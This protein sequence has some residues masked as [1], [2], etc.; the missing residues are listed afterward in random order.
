MKL[1]QIQNSLESLSGLGPAK[2]KLF[3]R[4]N[5]FTVADLLSAYPKKYEDRSKKIPLCQFQLYPKVY[6][7][8]K[9]LSHEWFGYGKMKTLKIFISDGSAKAC[10]VAFNRPFLEKN[11]PVSSIIQ[12]CGKFEERYGQIQSTSFEAEVIYHDGNLEEIQKNFHLST[13]MIPIYSLCQGLSQKNYQKAVKEALRIYG[14]SIEDDLPPQIVKE[15]N[16][17][18]KSE[19]LFKI[20]NPK[21]LQDINL[22]RKTII[23]EELFFFE[24][25][26]ALRSLDHRGSLP[27]L[28]FSSQEKSP[29][30]TDQKEMDEKFR[31]S[32][33]P[34][35]QELLKRLPF[36][37]TSDQK[38]V[39]L[40]MNREI[41]KSQ[42]QANTMITNPE[43][44]KANPFSMQRLLQG[45]VGSGKTLV[46]FFICLRSIDYGGQCAILAPTE[47]LAKQ[48]AENAAR[49]LEAL[50]VKVAFLTGNV[51][52]KGR[53]NLLNA[54]KEGLVNIVIGTHALFSQNVSYKKLTLAVIDE[55]HR[56]GV[57]QRESIIQKGRISNG[58][59]THT[60]DLLMMSATPIPQTLALTVFGDLDVSVIK[61]MPQGRKEIIT[62]LTVAGHEANAYEAVR[63]ELKAGH[64]A[65]FVY[66]RISEK[67]VDE[68]EDFSDLPPEENEQK[69]D[70]AGQD[71]KSAEEMFTFLSQ[72]VYPEYK[73]ALI[74]S[75]VAEEDQSKILEDFRAGKISVLVATTVVEVGVDV[76]NANCMV[77]E[78][79][80]RFGLAALHQLRGRVGRSALQSY[81]FLIYSK[82][83]SQEGKSRLKALYETKD[84]FKIAEEDLKLRGPGEVSGTL[85]SGYLALG[86]SDLV[87]D[88]E[89]LKLARYDAFKFIESG[90]KIQN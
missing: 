5:I 9:V 47:L 8:C 86:L 83:I 1:S 58:S 90:Q 60:P 54:L 2:A 44:L 25:K 20:H 74:H 88:K 16:L 63:K 21:N 46:A 75:K 59:L 43:K 52:S 80:E 30:F 70:S 11:L 45:D 73:C 82:N 71:I 42:A 33:S 68:K 38:S 51:K 39:I 18:S 40:E 37:L 61:T 6:T 87:R 48:H 56:F 22:A 67:E 31:L 81:C 64:Q 36:S 24:Y 79:A 76:A 7:I 57:S 32:L 26:L 85:Q 35:Q 10:L 69:N 50:G 4:L 17:L 62:H 89:V 14:K 65:Y 28:E 66:P 23:Y 77:I 15:R 13:G 53:S 34:R 55:Q 3:S 19:S 29:S 12:V 78:G 84:G 72:Q 41:D 27:A 49:L